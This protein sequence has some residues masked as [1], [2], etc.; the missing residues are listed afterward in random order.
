MTLTF[1][2][3]AFKSGDRFR[4]GVDIDLFSGIDNFGATPSELIGSLFSF[5]FSDG[6]AVQSALDADLTA[7][8]TLPNGLPT[9]VGDPFC[10]ANV[11][12]GTTTDDPDPVPTNGPVPAP[13]PLPILGVLSA[14]R[15]ARTLRKRTKMAFV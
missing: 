4:F 15:C 7:S 3:N 11:P 1:A 9:F 2:D 13:G 14:L 10:G 12:P 8:S 6:F 5:V